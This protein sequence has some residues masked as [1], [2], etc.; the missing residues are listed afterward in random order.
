M[1]LGW[2][3]LFSSTTRKPPKKEE[4]TSDECEHWPRAAES[5][6]NVSTSK[7]EGQGMQ[8]EWETMRRSARGVT[9]DS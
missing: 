3:L 5:A 6:E 4:E 9:T 1:K 8:E 7:F 2:Q